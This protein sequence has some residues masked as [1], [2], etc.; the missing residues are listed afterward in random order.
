MTF[1]QKLVSLLRCPSCGNEKRFFE[2]TDDVVTTTYYIQNA[3]GSFT[4]DT[5]SSEILGDAKLFCSDCEEDLTSF[6]QRFSEM[7]F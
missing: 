3:D 7:I 4:I 2:I 6:H 5:Q 1:P